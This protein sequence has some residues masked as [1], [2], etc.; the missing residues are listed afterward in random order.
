MQE[1]LDTVTSALMNALHDFEASVTAGDAGAA[2]RQSELRKVLT[3]RLA[4]LENKERALWEKYAEGMPPKIFDDLIAKNGKQKEEVT[5]MLEQLDS[6][7]QPINYEERVV[8]FSETLDALRDPDAPAAEV[9]ALLKTCIR[10]I[11][12]SRERGKRKRGTRDGWDVKPMNLQIE[13]N[14]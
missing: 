4:E 2:D 9:N 3:T 1:M 5:A 8:L 12:Y 14:L 7:P 11:T 10:R 6:E 13:L